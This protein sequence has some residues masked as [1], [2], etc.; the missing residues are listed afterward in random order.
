MG[1]NFK[2]KFIEVYNT[3]IPYE[4][5]TSIIGHNGLTEVAKE[6]LEGKYVFPLVIHLN[7]IDVFDHI[8][9]TDKILR[10][11]FIH[12]NTKI[13]D[14]ATFL[15]TRSQKSSMSGMHNGIILLRLHQPS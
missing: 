12:A 13:M 7:I 15:E 11:E 4:L 10:E 14:F 2:K 6:I 8:R 1:N 9:M 3:P 5:F